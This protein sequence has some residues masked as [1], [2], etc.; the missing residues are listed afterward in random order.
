MT[1]PADICRDIRGE[2]E[3]FHLGQL[4]ESDAARVRDHVRDCPA[5]AAE[6]D[7]VCALFKLAEEIETIEPSAAFRREMASLIDSEFEVSPRPQADRG[8]AAAV[9]TLLA[10]AGSRFKASRRFRVVTLSAAAHVIVLAVLTFFVLPGA[11]DGPDAIIVFRDF[12]Q[13]SDRPDE[14]SDDEPGVPVDDGVTEKPGELVEVGE[15]LPLPTRTTE[16]SLGPWTAD[17]KNP[18]QSVRARRQF[19]NDLVAA[20]MMDRIDEDRKATRLKSADRDERVAAAVRA[21]LAALARTQRE[22]GS[23][24]CGREYSGYEDGVTSLAVLAFLGNGQSAQR[25]EYRKTVSRAAAWLRGRQQKNGMIGDP[26]FDRP[27]YGHALATLAMVEIYG[28][29][30]EFMAGGRSQLLRRIRRAIQWTESAQKA[31]GGWRYVARSDESDM[32]PGDASV[33]IWQVLALGA[34][35]DAGLRVSTDILSRA[36]KFL[37][38]RTRLVDGVLGYQG[39]PAAGKSIDLTLTAGALAAGPH[40][41]ESKDLARLRRVKLAASLPTSNDVTDPL[42]WFYAT[43]GLRG[44]GDRAFAS[45]TDFTTRTLLESQLANGSWAP[46]VRHGQQ[47]GPTYATAMSVLILSVDYRDSRP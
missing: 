2:L 8:T 32:S 31:D 42:L 30:Y 28:L 5:C 36:R 13:M 7:E 45:W 26:E 21:G 29:D 12:G 19:P 38:E 18:R 34:A 47:G 9:L 24:A 11:N 3:A 33:T 17:P 46:E 44:T 20:W 16:P 22:D 37:L 35:R 40:L 4:G 23:W 15:W 14:P 27:M 1:S 10:F 39:T 43:L 25:G 41:H 6:F